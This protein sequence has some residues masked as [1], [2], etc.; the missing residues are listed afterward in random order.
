MIGSTTLIFFILNSLLQ[1][2]V[3][4]IKG[5]QGVLGWATLTNSVVLR[6]KGAFN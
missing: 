5:C 4:S 6:E 3:S 1:T 2:L